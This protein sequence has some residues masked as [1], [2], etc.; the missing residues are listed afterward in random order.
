MSHHD[1]DARIGNINNMNR[2]DLNNNTTDYLAAQYAPADPSTQPP[3]GYDVP[4]SGASQIM[5]HNLHRVA[6]AHIL[7]EGNRKNESGDP[8]SPN[9]LSG[10]E[11]GG[12]GGGEG[13]ASL[14]VFH[15]LACELA[16]AEEG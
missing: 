14:S 13:D 12:K 8:A 5:A 6:A 15:I 4:D 1:M 2:N 3:P 9:V 16:D 10:Q 11:G 7:Y